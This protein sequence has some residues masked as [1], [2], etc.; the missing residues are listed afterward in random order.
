MLRLG[1]WNDST[2]SSILKEVMEKLMPV[3]V[4]IWKY[5]EIDLLKLLSLDF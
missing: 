1:R 2:M 3:I 5:V 4:V